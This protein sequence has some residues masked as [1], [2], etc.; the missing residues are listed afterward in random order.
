MLELKELIPRTMIITHVKSHAEKRKKTEQFTLPEM[1]Y[2][3]VDSIISEQSKTPIN[4]H[5]FN[6]PIAVY[7][8]NIY[9]QNNYS[10][11]IKI[12]SGEPI[13]KEFMI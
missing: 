4:T 6:T 13:A 2:L 10:L 12:R 7:V 11:A 5:I 3:R 9:H 1:L 8:D